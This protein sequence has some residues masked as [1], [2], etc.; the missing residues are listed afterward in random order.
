MVVIDEPGENHNLNM[1]ID[2]QQNK[3]NEAIRTNF[4]F[5]IF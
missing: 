1:K 4:E 2:V 5:K 3:L